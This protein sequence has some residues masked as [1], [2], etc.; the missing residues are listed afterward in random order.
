MKKYSKLVADTLDAL[1][2]VTRIR[3]LIGA[4]LRVMEALRDGSISAAESNTLTKAMN[5]Q[6]IK[7]SKTAA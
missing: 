6:R 5:K 3:D 4:Q 1:P 7:I 2:H